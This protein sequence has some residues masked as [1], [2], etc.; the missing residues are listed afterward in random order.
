MAGACHVTSYRNSFPAAPNDGLT[1]CVKFAVQIPHLLTG[2]NSHSGTV[3]SDL[4]TAGAEGIVRLD[5][6]HVVCPDG[7]RV[8]SIGAA[9]KVMA[10]ALDDQPDIMLPRFTTKGAVSTLVLSKRGN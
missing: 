2:A 4:A 5:P 6:F 8:G 7:E 9:D 3:D 1:K 10:A